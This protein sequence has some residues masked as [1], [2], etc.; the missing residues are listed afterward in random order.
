MSCVN[1]CTCMRNAKLTASG[2]I[3]IMI[4]STMVGFLYV[5]TPTELELNNNSPLL[6]EED[7]NDQLQPEAPD[8]GK[9][10]VSNWESNWAEACASF[11][12]GQT[13][14]CE[15]SLDDAK[16]HNQLLGELMNSG[17]LLGISDIPESADG[18]MNQMDAMVAYSGDDEIVQRW[19]QERTQYI[20]TLDS[21]H[22][23]LASATSDLTQEQKAWLKI[24]SMMEIGYNYC[25]NAED[26]TQCQEDIEALTWI[27]GFLDNVDSYENVEQSWLDSIMEQVEAGQGGATI[28]SAAVAFASIGYW[29]THQAYYT[30]GSGG[31]GPLDWLAKAFDFVGYHIAKATDNHDG[32]VGADKSAGN[33]GGSGGGHIIGGGTSGDLGSIREMCDSDTWES[34]IAQRIISSPE[35]SDLWTESLACP[36]GYLESNPIQCLSAIRGA[37]YHNHVLSTVM[38][39]L[40][41]LDGF[42]IYGSS[43][44]DGDDHRKIVANIMANWDYVVRST[45]DEDLARQYVLERKSLEASELAF[46]EGREKSEDFTLRDIQT[47]AQGEIDQL[48]AMCSVNCTTMDWIRDILDFINNMNDNT[49]DIDFEDMLKGIFESDA[50]RVTDAEH[51][52][53]QAAFNLHATYVA[54]DAYWDAESSARAPIWWKKFGDA[55]GGFCGWAGNSLA[56]NNELA[57]DCWQSG[58]NSVKGHQLSTSAGGSGFTGRD[59]VWC[60][61]SIDVEND[62][63]L[64]ALGTCVDENIEL[65]VRENS[66]FA[67][68]LQGHSKSCGEYAS[69]VDLSVVIGKKTYVEGDV[70]EGVI[71]ADCTL[72]GFN[73]VMKISVEDQT[74]GSV[75]FTSNYDWL[76]DDNTETHT[77]PVKDLLEG[78]YC[79]VVKL[80]DDAS[81]ANTFTSQACFDVD[82][83]K[84]DGGDDANDGDADDD[85][86]GWPIPGF[87]GMTAFIAMLGAAIIAFRRLEDQ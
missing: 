76:E 28:D 5:D 81:P 77:Q 25:G 57:G 19:N 9:I 44:V 43:I 22:Q 55:L 39:T 32:M 45:G 42:D 75:E 79:M 54:S 15:S 58:R 2:I 1:M 18:E 83:A 59:V 70:V 13:D 26:A 87:T 71:T 29:N 63:A 48:E 65:A 36:A 73:Y 14:G 20:E 33:Q 60:V 50:F 67:R 11:S 61:A 3:A 49:T 85:D 86:D 34:C 78:S 80:T 46:W 82:A 40:A 31:R 30:G 12:G 23:A 16:L 6:A 24:N 74:S 64:A 51:P 68:T 56:G 62:E 35:L 17:K 37:N 69:L 10:L 41:E 72:N 4:L 53:K 52:H 8:E 21:Y 38:S 7:T 27:E 47:M 84:G 66:D